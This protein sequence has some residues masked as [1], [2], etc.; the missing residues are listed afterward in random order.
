M[1]ILSDPAT[2]P[3]GIV[4]VSD[5]VAIGVMSA[6][7]KLGLSLPADLSVIGLDG[8]P[9][10]EAFGLTTMVQHVGRQ[11]AMAVSQALALLGGMAPEAESDLAMAPPVDLK[12]RSSTGP[13]PQRV[14]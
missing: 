4:A 8:H 3:T 13:P 7:Y 11:G 10:G 9:M 1:K 2:R 14:C 6:A 5:E 12:V